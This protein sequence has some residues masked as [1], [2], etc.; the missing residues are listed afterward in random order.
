M[1]PNR[2]QD[3]FIE[4]LLKEWDLRLPQIEGKEIASL[5]FGGGTP[6][7]CAEGIKQILQK[8][9]APEITVETNPEDVTPGLMK[10][11]HDLGVNRVSIGVQSLNNTLLKHLGR[12]HTAQKALDAVNTAYSAG[13][14]NI[15]IDLMYEIPHQTFEMWKETVDAAV[16]LP[17]THLSLYNLTIEPHTAFKK[18]EHD[19]RLHLPDEETATEMLQ[20]ACDRFE[21]AKLHRYEISAFARNGKVSI[22]NTGYWTGREFLG[23]G[24]SAFSYYGGKRFQNVCHLNRYIKILEQGKFPVD[25]EEELPFPANLHEKIAIGLRLTKGIPLSNIPLDTQTI[26]TD[27]DREGF[28]VY[29]NDHAALTDRGRLFYDTVAEKI[30]DE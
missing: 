12:T 26:L 6:T 1:I 22:H 16:E 18:R 24:P 30:I 29:Q 21:E 9:Q 14:K 4:A 20:Y 27:L 23:Y 25:F 15:T 17:I 13:I 10:T 28:I 8:V 5:Y 11:L 3:P 19:L 2:D 7:L